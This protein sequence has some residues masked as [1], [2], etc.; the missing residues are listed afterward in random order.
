M[1]V[2]LINPPCEEKIYIS[3]PLG[4]AYIA[5]TLVD[6]G[7]HEVKIIDAA[8][9]ENGSANIIKKIGMFSPDLIGVTSMTPSFQSAITIAKMIKSYYKIPIVL[10][11]PH[12]TIMHEEIMK[13]FPEIDFIVRGEGEITINELANSMEKEKSF[14]KIKGLSYRENNKIINNP[15]R[16]LMENLDV[17]P[18]PARDLLPENGY[19]QPIGNPNSF[20]TLITSRGCP[21]SCVY[22][23]KSVFGKKF[24][25]RSPENIIKEIVDVIENHGV[26]E[27]VFYDDVFTLDK[28]RISKLCDLLIENKIDIPW[29]CESRVDLVDEKLLEKM[30]RAGCHIIAYGVE[31]GNSRLLKIINKGVSKKQIYEAFKKTKEFGIETLAYF[32]IGIPGETKKT[33]Q[34]T[35][36]FAIELDPDYVQFSIATPFPGTELYE[37]AKRKGYITSDYAW[38]DYRY[39]GKNVAPIIRTNELTQEDLKQELKRLIRNFYFRPR[40]I[41]KQMKKC[42]NLEVLKIKVINLYTLLNLSV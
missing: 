22:C 40:Y 29:K 16:P 11:G 2:L 37:T 36:N 39:F 10:G 30:G 13:N 6:W 38:D 17:L 24:R 41:A 9:G 33:I 12:A 4:I 21:F 26:K 14:K 23:S 20:T 34:E 18:F 5:S 1:K 27:I 3:P 28:S 7:G 19:R 8:L 25:F 35:L 32:M 31:S 15:Q 42:T